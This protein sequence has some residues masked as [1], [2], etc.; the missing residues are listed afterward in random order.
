[1]EALFLPYQVTTA[2]RVS[3][4]GADVP[5][6]DRSATPIAL[7]FHELATNATKY[8]ALSTDLGHVTVTSLIDGGDIVLVWQEE[9][10][11]PVRQPETAGF[12]TQLIDLSASRQLG[13]K[14]VYDWADEGLR[15]VVEVS[16]A[17][18]SRS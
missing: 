15:V 10:G 4:G 1:M 9:G 11:P 18:L 17:A 13:G 16:R 12:G 5:I 2:P 3:V 14:V 7:L 6:D 8:G